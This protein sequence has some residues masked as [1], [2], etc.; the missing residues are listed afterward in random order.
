M[1]GRQVPKSALVSIS[2]LLNGCINTPAK[3][4]RKRN[5]KIWIAK[6][7]P[8]DSNTILLIVRSLSSYRISATSSTISSNPKTGMYL[9]SREHQK[10]PV[11]CSL[12]QQILI[13]SR[14]KIEQRQTIIAN[15]VR[16]I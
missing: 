7:M 1:F 13:R 11:T 12:I 3:L 15:V 4:P 16:V 2:S 5:T 6:L 9:R 8:F 10:L 14:R